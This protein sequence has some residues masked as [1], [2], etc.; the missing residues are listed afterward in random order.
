MVPGLLF[1]SKVC[2]IV[3]LRRSRALEELEGQ[4]SSHN[5]FR[6]GCTAAQQGSRVTESLDQKL[7]F[8]PPASQ[9]GRFSL[10]SSGSHSR[11]PI[12]RFRTRYPFLRPVMRGRSKESYSGYSGKKLVM[13]ANPMHDYDFAIRA[14]GARN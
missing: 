7:A 13:F 2:E 14:L 4:Y 1:A 3:S 6:T 11:A 12:L 5:H 10:Q 9:F 8:T